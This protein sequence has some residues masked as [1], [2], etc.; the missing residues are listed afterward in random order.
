MF[1]KFSIFA[2]LALFVGLP[3][4]VIVG[5]LHFKGTMAYSSELDITV[6]SNPYQYKF[7]PGYQRQ[8]TGPLGLIV[9][10]L[11]T[12]I[13][14]DRKLLTDKERAEVERAREKLKILIEAEMVGFPRRRPFNSEPPIG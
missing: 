10:D 11:L 8:V 5:W 7:T 2:L 9:L 3:L 14:D 1:P 6:E 12:K 4:V 13:S